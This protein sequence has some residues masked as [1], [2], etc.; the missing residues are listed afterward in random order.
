MIYFMPEFRQWVCP[1]TSSMLLYTVVVLHGTY[2]T[3]EAQEANDTLGFRI[4]TTR[5]FTR[6]SDTRPQWPHP[7]HS[8]LLPYRNAII[9]LAPISAYDQVCA[10]PALSPSFRTDR[11][12]LHLILSLHPMPCGLTVPHSTVPRRGSSDKPNWRFP[13]T[14]YPHML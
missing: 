2:M 1:S 6:G 3:S 5:R 11:T 9:F 8:N 7:S 4:S 14:V 13:A 12:V 10:I